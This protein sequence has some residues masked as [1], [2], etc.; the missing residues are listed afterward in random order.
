[1][2]LTVVALSAV[3]AVLE[4][5]GVVVTVFDIRGLTNRIQTFQAT[6]VT[7]Y[8][9]AALHARA[10]ASATLT[11]GAPPTVEQRVSALEQRAST[12]DAYHPTM[13][14]AL[15]SEFAEMLRGSLADSE[16]TVMEQ[17]EALKKVAIGPSVS[18][19]RRY[20]GP[21]LVML[22]IVCGTTAAIVGAL[23]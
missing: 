1:V 21:A 22:G 15:R 11:G 19:G 12:H 2:T 6:G 4:V 16:R 7:R 9:R 3:A 20:L 14:E 5:G 23:K 17:F 13:E 10:S 8:L 18:R